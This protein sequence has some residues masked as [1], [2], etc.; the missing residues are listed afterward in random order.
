MKPA[1]STGPV[2]SHSFLESLLEEAP[3]TLPILRQSCI[4]VLN[5][6]QDKRSSASD[7]GEIIMRDQAMMANVIKIANSP[8]YHTR[9]PVKTPT[10]AVALIG[11]DVIRA[12]VVSA[13][14]IE[15]ADTFGANTTNLKHLLARALVAGTQA[16]ELGKAMKYGDGGSLFTNAMLYSLGDLILALCRSDA[17]DQLEAMRRENPDNIP[18]AE[19]ALLGRPLPIIAA[20][21]AKHWNLPDSLVQLL[22]K[23]P[24]WPQTRPEADQQI[25]GS[26]VRAANELSYCLLN[27]FAAGQGEVLQS[28]IK[29]FLPP[30]GLSMNQLEHTV[31]KAFSQASEISSAIN[32]DRRHFLPA[33]G[34]D[35]TFLHNQHLHRLTQTIRQALQPEGTGPAESAQQESSSLPPSPTSDRPLLDFTIQAMNI[36]EPSNLLTFATRTLYASYGFERVW[37]ALVVPGK[38]KLEAKIG[39]GPHSETIQDMF[40]CSLTRGNFWDRLLHQFH[41]IQYSSLVKEGKAGGMPTGF[42]QCW[43]DQPGFAGTLYAPNRPIGFILVDRGSTGH[44]LTDTDFAAFALVLSQTNANLARLAQNH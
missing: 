9:T 19:L 37:L 5:L 35:G 6:T 12:M 4:Q 14:L 25:M 33:S 13:Q 30:F 36:S 31:A 38:N 21:M 42:L 15:Q 29:Q 17:A 10:Y 44:P 26:I 34:A 24:V 39:Y 16:Q 27:P 1:T 2:T 7:I 40:H 32:I 22:E 18:K 41:P 43:G 23:K 28:L 20:T 3:N 8:A 11:F